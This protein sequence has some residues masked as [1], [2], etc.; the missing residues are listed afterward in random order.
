MNLAIL[1]GC[2]KLQQELLKTKAVITDWK[3]DQNLNI[4]NPTWS[5]IN[6]LSYF[7]HLQVAMHHSQVY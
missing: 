2:H 7:L 5:E 6:R 1:D 4:A 3:N